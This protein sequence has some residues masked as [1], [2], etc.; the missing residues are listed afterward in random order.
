MANKQSQTIGQAISEV[1]ELEKKL[2]EI[3]IKIDDRKKIIQNYF[4]ENGIKKLEVSSNRTDVKLVAKKTERVTLKYQIDKLKSKLNSEVFNEITK[5]TYTINDIDAMIKLLKAN[6]IVAKD[7]KNLLDI[8]IKVD[9]ATIK[10][11]YD[12]GEISMK[13]IKGCY[14]A[15]ITKNIKI[16]EGQGDTD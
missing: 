13:D 2:A 8:D 6:G 7:F 16:E 14:E 3:L 11:L 15:T 9:S 12:A 10:R 1:Y 5:R 4:D